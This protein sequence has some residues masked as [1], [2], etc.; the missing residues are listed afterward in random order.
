MM[1]SEKI[2]DIKHPEIDEVLDKLAEVVDDERLRKIEHRKTFKNDRMATSSMAP[3]TITPQDFMY[4]SGAY[5]MAD[6]DTLREYLEGNLAE[7][8]RTDFS[9]VFHRVYMRFKSEH[10]SIEVLEALC[11][12]YGVEEDYA[13]KSLN[14][15]M[16]NIIRETLYRKTKDKRL[17]FK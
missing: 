9:M 1:D 17:K 8:R 16:Q 12:V 6:I 5:D 7:F 14:I 2:F 3:S 11:D 10:N 15:N 4:E 13:F